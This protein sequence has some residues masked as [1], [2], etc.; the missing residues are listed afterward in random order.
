MLAPSVVPR[1]PAAPRLARAVRAS[2]AALALGAAAL[3]LRAGAQAPVPPD[4]TRRPV[5]PAAPTDTAGA[6]RDTLARPALARRPR[7]A[8]A[9]TVVRPPISARRAFI[10]SVLLPGYGQA[11]LDRPGAGALFLAVEATALVMARKSLGDLREAKRLRGDSIVPT[12]V[13]VDTGLVPQLPTPGR[14]RNQFTAGLVRSRRLH[15]EDWVAV[16]AFNHLFAGAEAF[17]AANLWDLPAQ[18][19]ARRTENGPALAVRLAW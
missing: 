13:P 12:I 9:D 8:V 4:T 19:S 1:T 15:F 17:V 14:L 7:A 10:S 5:V 11:R 3:P 18:V 2:L 16:I 6:R